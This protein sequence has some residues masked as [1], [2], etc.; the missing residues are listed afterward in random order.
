MIKTKQDKDMINHIS[1]VYTENNTELSG[2]MDG[3]GVIGDETKQDN[4][5]TNLSHA[6]YTGNETKLS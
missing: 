3:T 5:V 4:D 1:L 2:P 6:V